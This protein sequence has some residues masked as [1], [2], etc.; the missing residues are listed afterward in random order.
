MLERLVP[1]PPGAGCITKLG[2]KIAHAAVRVD[3]IRI[4][5]QR[6]FEMNTRR[7]LLPAHEQQI[8]QIDMPVRIIRMMPHRL[9]EQRAGGVLVAGSESERAEIV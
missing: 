8:R 7:F 2:Q 5:L 4:D 6:R 1:V 3:M 9:A